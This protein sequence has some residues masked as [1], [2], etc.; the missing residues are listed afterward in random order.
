MK[1]VYQYRE[2]ILPATVMPSSYGS[3][4]H[5]PGEGPVLPFCFDWTYP[6]RCHALK[7]E[8]VGSMPLSASLAAFGGYLLQVPSHFADFRCEPLL[9][10]LNFL[11]A[12][13]QPQA[14]SMTYPRVNNAYRR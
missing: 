2:T 4:S 6:G 8:V 5:G 12:V 7:G 14:T 13:K 1:K 9:P 10:S 3:H 11:K